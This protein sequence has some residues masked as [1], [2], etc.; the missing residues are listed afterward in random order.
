MNPSFWLLWIS[1]GLLI[2]A[3]LLMHRAACEQDARLKWLEEM[4]MAEIAKKMKAEPHE[5]FR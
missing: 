3:A 4:R 5:R 2:A 1:Q